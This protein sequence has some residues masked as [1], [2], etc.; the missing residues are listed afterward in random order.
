MYDWRSVMSGRQGL[1]HLERCY[2]GRTIPQC[3]RLNEV[4]RIDRITSGIGVQ[5]N[6][7]YRSLASWI[8]GRR[9][10]QNPNEIQPNSTHTRRE[11]RVATQQ[12]RSGP[13]PIVRRAWAAWS[14]SPSCLSCSLRPQRHQS[15]LTTPAILPSFHHRCCYRVEARYL[16]VPVT[17]LQTVQRPLVAL[18]NRKSHEGHSCNEYVSSPLQRGS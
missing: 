12:H 17:C 8:N 1:V 18:Y 5:F 10:L 3:K 15:F 2:T 13:K 4:E 14:I 7:V 11:L 6:E 16:L 9:C